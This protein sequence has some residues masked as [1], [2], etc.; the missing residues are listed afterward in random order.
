MAEKKGVLIQ[1]SEMDGRTEVNST[2]NK[3][4]TRAVLT[5]ALCLFYGIPREHAGDAAAF[6]AVLGKSYREDEQ[7]DPGSIPDFH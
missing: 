6:L 7:G 2:G 3:E 5:E 4:E 1:I